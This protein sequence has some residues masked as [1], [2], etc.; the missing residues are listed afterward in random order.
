MRFINV[1]CVRFGFFR[2]CKENALGF[3]RIRVAKLNY[4]IRSDN[5]KVCVCIYLLCLS[6]SFDRD[7]KAQKAQKRA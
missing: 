3:L 6:M 7:K 1:T 5:Q 4:L 2:F